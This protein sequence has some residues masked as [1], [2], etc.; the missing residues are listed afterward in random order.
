[1]D[2]LLTV[3]IP[4]LNRATIVGRTL[5]SLCRQTAASFDV[6]L[7]DNGSTDGTMEI[8]HRWQAANTSD[9]RRITVISCSTRGAAAARNAGLEYTTTP[10]VL[11]FDSDD[12]MQPSHIQRVTDGITAHSEADILGWDV[13]IEGH[14]VKRFHVN[15]A[16]WYN[17]FEGNFATQRWTARTSLVGKVGAWGNDILLWDDIELGARLLCANPN[18][19]RLDGISVVIHPQE[20]SISYNGD[21]SHIERCEASLTSIAKCLPESKRIWTEYKRMI[22]AGNSAREGRNA[23]TASAA[24]IDR[25]KALRDIVLRRAPRLHRPL[26]LAVYHFR[27]LGGRGQNRLLK[28]L[29]G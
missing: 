13:L 5:E 27:R 11:F 1:M 22:V 25:A 28:L 29:I 9:S 16:M 6:V 24:I 7:V 19:A 3:I 15:N 14:G 2:K 12:E 20:E 8:L 10:W 4:V 18:I 21:G 17:L 23:G 26:L